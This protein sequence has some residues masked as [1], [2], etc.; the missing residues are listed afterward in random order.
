MKVAFFIGSLNR[1]GTEMLLLDVCRR[2]RQAPFDM[3]VVYRN[4][5]ELSEQY[6]QTGVKM[7]RLKPKHGR[8]VSYLR[9]MRQMLKREN[10]DILHAQTLTNGVFSILCTKGL[11]TKAITT[12]H[13]FP[14]GHLANL[15]TRF[16]ML[17]SDMLFYVSNYVRE[18]YTGKYKSGIE[19]S[20]TVYNGVDFS[21]LDAKYEIPDFLK[22]I[23]SPQARIKDHAADDAS[24][25]RLAMIGN[26]VSGRSQNSLLRSIHLLIS[27]GTRNFDFYFVGKR[28]DSE[29]YLYDDCVRY[30]QSN[31]LLD[32]V[33]F[34]GGRGD[35]PAILQN[36]DAFVYSTEHDT[37]GIAVVEAM[38]AGIP[39]VANDWQ[40]MQEITRNGQWAK[41]YTTDNIEAGAD[42][43]AELILHLDE[44]K[45][46]A[47]QRKQDVR[48]AFS[49]DKHIDRLASLYQKLR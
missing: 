17:R 7:L 32:N 45:T 48:E 11:P 39:V 18:W 25:I 30:A 21:K 31:D 43:I 8:Y 3:V 2:H 4:E 27:R 46:Q 5:G 23:D 33:H 14:L 15:M 37:F 36:I 19:N 6:H 47:L 35:V 20:Y 13:G 28:A 22:K 41:L 24:R 26:F 1:G 10:V 40:V 12:F 29:G 49:I 42:A 34:V 44:Y 16:V 38:A 9:A